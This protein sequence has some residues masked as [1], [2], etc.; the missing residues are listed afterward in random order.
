MNIKNIIVIKDLQ[1]FI[2]S[3]IVIFTV[4]SLLIASIKKKFIFLFLFILFI[5]IFNFTLYYGELFYLFFIP[6]ILFL[7]IFYLY[8]LRIESDLSIINNEENYFESIKL[9]NDEYKNK[10]NKNNL[11]KEK[12]KKICAFIMPILF[13]A[14]FVF[15][16]FKFSSNYTAKFNMEKNI[17]LIN[18]SR[19]AEEIYINYEIII[20]IVVLLIFIIFLWIISLILIR[21]KD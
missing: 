2:L 12:S 21:K 3:A 19:I 11:L 18:F 5:Q 7:V 9:N 17:T 16:F 15:L 13:C 14:G 4:L 1:Y 20:F 8:N 6:L 10:E